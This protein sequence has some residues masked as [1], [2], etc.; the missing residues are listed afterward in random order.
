MEGPWCESARPN[1]PIR[2][3]DIAM[4][5]CKD[6]SSLAITLAPQQ[7]TP[8]GGASL[9]H[10][11]W[12]WV[13]AV[14]RQS[15]SPNSAAARRRFH[16]HDNLRAGFLSRRHARRLLVV[17]FAATGVAADAALS[18]KVIH[19]VQVFS[20]AAQQNNAALFVARASGVARPK[21][22]SA[23]QDDNPYGG[24]NTE[25]DHQRLHPLRS[26]F[27]SG[28]MGSVRLLANSAIGVVPNLAD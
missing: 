24:I 27:F 20:G 5:D 2:E 7:M 16:R 18:M 13:G 25:P 10:W 22:S 12:G 1:R 15:R 3:V 4:F 28:L 26:S 6:T 23:P 14:Q 9:S 21:K 19:R 11:T 8:V 17:F